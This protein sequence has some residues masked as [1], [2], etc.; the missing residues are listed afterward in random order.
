MAV[1]SIATEWASD[2]KQGY[3]KAGWWLNEKFCCWE[4]MDPAGP[5]GST[6]L[7]RPPLKA[8]SSV[9]SSLVNS[10]S[11]AALTRR[12]LEAALW[13]HSSLLMPRADRVAAGT[14]ELSETCT[15]WV[16]WSTWTFPAWLIYVFTAV[17]LPKQ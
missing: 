11:T 14:G 9:T 4:M 15:D 5:G 6:P 1:I 16:P 10:S 7:A 3:C 12:G 2:L 8:I 13:A 17:S